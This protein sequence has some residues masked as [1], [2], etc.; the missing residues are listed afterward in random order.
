[1]IAV[2]YFPDQT[3]PGASLLAGSLADPEVAE[4]SACTNEQGARGDR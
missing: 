2:P 1:M 4:R 3:V